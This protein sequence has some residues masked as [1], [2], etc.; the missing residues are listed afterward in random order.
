MNRGAV[1]E[2]LRQLQR[3]FTDAGVGV[4]QSGQ[5][6]IFGE[7]FS[8]GECMKRCHAPLRRLGGHREFFEERYGR[9]NLAL[10]QEARR[11]VATPA[12]GMVEQWNEFGRR[13]FAEPRCA[14]DFASLRNDAPNA[15]AFK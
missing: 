8:G 6:V 15:A 12:V 13:S 11:R 2:A 9:A 10:I 1:S 7:R 3:L 5:Y 14:P 4:G